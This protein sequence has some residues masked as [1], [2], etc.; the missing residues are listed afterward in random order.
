MPRQP[1]RTQHYLKL[2]KYSTPRNISQL[3]TW[4][5][6]VSDLPAG[7]RCR[8]QA[9]SA[10]QAI[11]AELLAE[12]FEDNYD[13]LGNILEIM[14]SNTPIPMPT[15]KSAISDK[16]LLLNF[17]R[18]ILQSTN[19][20]VIILK[21]QLKPVQDF[22]TYIEYDEETHSDADDLTLSGD[23]DSDAEDYLSVAY[24]V[25][26][27][28]STPPSV[29]TWMLDYGASPSTP[30]SISSL[31]DDSPYSPFLWLKKPEHPLVTK[32]RELSESNWQLDSDTLADFS[33]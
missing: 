16:P 11:S 32:A 17:V 25:R 29:N 24:D 31:M 4:L 28:A 3:Q 2:H 27:S 26:N 1:R 13:L 22:T 9:N 33:L 20:E 6:N 7:H 5:K 10:A 30:N 15:I 8:A 12:Y 23:T 21:D 19:I 18:N 14:L